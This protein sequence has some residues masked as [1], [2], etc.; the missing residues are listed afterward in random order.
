MRFSRKSK[1]KEYDVSAG[2]RQDKAL[3]SMHL[4]VRVCLKASSSYMSSLSY[5]TKEMS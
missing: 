5:T 1:K 2:F 4:Y 3:V